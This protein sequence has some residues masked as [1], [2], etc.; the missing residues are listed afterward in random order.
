MHL[1]IILYYNFL[2]YFEKYL[3]QGGRGDEGSNLQLYLVVPDRL[4][5][6]NFA[7]SAHSSESKRRF[8]RRKKQL[9]NW[10]K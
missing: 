5:D 6:R 9:K 10:K 4:S 1:N 3:T 7:E 8:G 2:Q